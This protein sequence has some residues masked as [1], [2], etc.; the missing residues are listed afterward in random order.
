MKRWLR[1]FL[2]LV[3]ALAGTAAAGAGV[4]YALES[5]QAPPILVVEPQA[6]REQAAGLLDTLCAGD[7]TGASAYFSGHPDLGT[8]PE[9]A[10]D[11]QKEIWAAFLQ[12]LRYEMSGDLYATD[13]GVAVD[14]TIT[15][16]EIPTVTANLKARSQAILQARVAQAEEMEEIYDE[17]N[18]YR[19]SFVMDCL[20]QAVEEALTQDG[21]S[22]QEQL[23]LHM[24]YQEG[25]WLVLPE[26]PLLSALSG[27]SR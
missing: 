21:T 8:L 22:R 12:S 27:W 14:V 17:N 16:L 24:I 9:D 23:T 18:N 7:Y 11:A 26:Q 20:H 6:A 4:Y 15:A 3:F 25:T 19:E 13:S 2:A 5:R 1:I 10:M